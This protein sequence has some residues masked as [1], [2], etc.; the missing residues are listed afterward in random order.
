M[1]DVGM[2]AGTEALSLL[3][4]PLNVHILGALGDEPR[5]MIDLRR[6]A[7]L[8]PPTTMRKALTMLTTRGVV[9]RRREVRFPGAAEYELTQSGR[10][11]RD[12]AAAVEHWLEQSPD[13]KVA[14]GSPASK[15]ALKALVEGWSTLVLRALAAKPLTLTELSQLINGVSYPSLE[16]RLK[17]LRITRQVEAERT[18]SGTPYSVTPWLRRAMAPLA[19]AISWELEHPG[20][21]IGP[22]GRLDAEAIFLLLVP[23]VTLADDEGGSCRI[24]IE[25][26]GVGHEFR[27]AGVMAEWREGKPIAWS[28]RLEGLADASVT[29]TTAAWLRALTSGTVDGL[30][31]S[32]DLALAKS[33]AMGMAA[34][35]FKNPLDSQRSMRESAIR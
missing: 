25:S 2:R 23:V 35:T 15:N 9:E 21:Q 5:T 28:S 24:A 1:G 8:A 34:S 19:A 32:G 3:S 31:S 20:R 4:T 12:V 33:V 7:E 26:R 22:L 6:E 10:R 30:E 17:A 18:G 27:F 29:G 11:L 16:R 14:L 13:G